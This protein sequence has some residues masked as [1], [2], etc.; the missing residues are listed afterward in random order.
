M[1][2]SIIVAIDKRGGIGKNGRIPWKLTNDLKR[3]K[4][5]TM[6]HHILMGR[7]TWDS[8][9]RQLVGRKIIII[10]RNIH[11]Q[12]NDNPVF[13]TVE[14][15]INYAKDNGEKELFII[16][17]GE[18]YKKVMNIVDRIYMTRVFFESGADVFFPE[19]KPHYWN[20]EYQEFFP[21]DEMNPHNSV[22]EIYHR[23]R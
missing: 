6:G 4:R 14:S 8:I 5:I 23:K 16:G 2:L 15:G 13:S 18:I 11:F 19:M 17:G 7:K 12:A 22:F 20:L 10:S 3:F 21:S 1:I 9:P